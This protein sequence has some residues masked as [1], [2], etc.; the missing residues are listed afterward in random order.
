MLGLLSELRKTVQRWIQQIVKY[1]TTQSAI[2]LYYNVAKQCSGIGN[3]GNFLQHVGCGSKTELTLPSSG[4]AAPTC[5]CQLVLPRSDSGEP[6]ARLEVPHPPPVPTPQGQALKAMVVQ[7]IQRSNVM[8][9][10]WLIWLTNGEKKEQH[11]ADNVV[12]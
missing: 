10:H 4:T 12:Q 6:P 8:T 3:N 7:T 1:S 5:V 11:S 2:P 9:V